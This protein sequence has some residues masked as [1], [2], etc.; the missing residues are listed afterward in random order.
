MPKINQYVVF[1]VYSFFF[2][3]EAIIKYTSL[4]SIHGVFNSRTGGA[5]KQNATFQKRSWASRKTFAAGNS[6]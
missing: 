3:V 2:F 6:I 1:A 4:K 5:G